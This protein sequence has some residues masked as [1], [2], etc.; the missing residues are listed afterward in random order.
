MVSTLASNS[1]KGEQ[2]SFP[3][4]P[5]RA[6]RVLRACVRA[7]CVHMC[8]V[9][10]ATLQ[11]AHDR[12]A[13]G[14]QRSLST[15]SAVVPRTRSE[16]NPPG[17]GVSPGR[18]PPFR[19]PRLAPPTQPLPSLL[20]RRSIIF[21]DTRDRDASGHQVSSLSAPHF[22]PALSYLHSLS[23]S[24]LRPSPLF[25]SLCLSVSLF[26]S[27]TVLPGVCACA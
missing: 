8:A 1:R 14:R 27:P 19:P 23:P 24:A 11:F 3:R 10:R 15:N 6:V 21:D 9:V 12:R 2:A 18:I 25:V 22:N 4:A 17:T 26:V 20:A 16:L 13:T 5:P 7:S